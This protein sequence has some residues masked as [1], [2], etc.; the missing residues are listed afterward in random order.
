K[1][2]CG[3]VDV[4]NTFSEGML[5]SCLA[6]EST[7]E[8]VA[9]LRAFG[10]WLNGAH[11]HTPGILDGHKP[12][13]FCFHHIGPYPAYGRDAL[14]GSIPVLGDLTGTPFELGP[15]AA[16]ILRQA[17]VTMNT[18]STTL[19]WPIGLCG[20][21]PR[22]GEGIHALVDSYALL[23]RAP[24]AG[25]DDG[26]GIDVEMASIFRGLVRE[27]ATEWQKALD[28]YF[29]DRGV[30][31]APAPQGY[32][33][34]GYAALGAHRQDQW[35]ASVKGL[36]R[37]LWSAETYEGANAYGRYLSYGQIEVQ[38]IA[39]DD[40]LVTH[41]AGGWHQPGYDWNHIPGT[42]TIVLPYDE[43]KADLTGTIQQSLL[44]DSPVGGA[45]T[46]A[47][48]ATL[49]GMHL[50]E[51]P[52]FNPTHTARISVLLV[53]DRILAL[54]SDIRND[55][56]E[57]PTHTTLFQLTPETMRAPHPLATG[58]NWAIDPAGN[59]YVV[60]H[61][62]MAA[63]TAPQTGPDQDGTSPGEARDFALGWIDH[64][65]QPTDGGYEYALLVGAGAEQ[66]EAFATAMAGGEKPWL[67]TQRDL[68]AHVV[69]D[70]ASGVSAHV[71][72]EA[73]ADLV[74]HSCVRRATRPCLVLLHG[75]GRIVSVSITDPDLHLYEGR[76]PDQYDDSG[77]HTGHYSSY[78]RPWRDTPSPPTSI[79]VVL[80]GAW[81]IPQGRGTVGG[82]ELATDGDDT[83][84]TLITQHAASL[85]FQLERQEAHPPTASKASGLGYSSPTSDGDPSSTIPVVM[86]PES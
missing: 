7:Q 3:V 23:G 37:Y 48:R 5:V 46:L 30:E 44:T 31:A 81:T 70:R 63:R 86:R 47:G 4:L 11:R 25:R 22:G 14:I 35:M 50:R 28:G 64:G 16:A 42:T 59:G 19:E 29:A 40:G 65:T 32:W 80:R 8:R 39:N 61:G 52:T 78:S 51:H 74:E 84:V 73:D 75:A 56:T 57:H 54:G 45:G 15:A 36:N 6:A 49:F 18:V 24:L 55:D 27:S 82:P 2:L 43:L 34:H 1:D 13:G 20:R 72:F 9:R 33:Q 12:D 10:A 66:T 60:S 68:V 71:V 76:D 67:V 38:S 85:E 69:S 26:T 53:G 58:S 62:S 41:E 21:H 77:D 83:R 79:S 17:M